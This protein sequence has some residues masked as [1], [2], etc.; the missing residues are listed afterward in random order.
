M[1]DTSRQMVV[2]R[3]ANEATR[4]DGLPLSPLSEAERR[5]LERLE[6][7]IH[8]A[9][10]Y[11]LQMAR[12]L[13]TIRQKRLYRKDH[14]TFEDYCQHRWSFTG[15]QGRRLCQ[16]VEVTQN[17]RDQ[18]PPIG[19]MVP[20]RESHARPLARLTPAQQRTAWRQYL[21]TVPASHSA[22]AIR[23]VCEQVAR[24]PVAE[25]LP[26]PTI[27]TAAEGAKPLSSPLTWYGGKAVLAQRIVDLLPPHH[28]YVEVFF[29]SGSVF[30]RKPPSPVEL[31]N[32]RNAEVVSFFQLLRDAAQAKEL[33]RLLR[34]TPY[35]RDEHD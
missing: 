29:G 24:A 11:M 17:L 8:T 25:G 20:L 27:G 10:R 1:S 34:L 21:R 13:W 7:I 12:A 33:Q 6:S 30:F 9:H 5:R 35:S 3:R 16:W 31:I 14:R 32:D 26:S 2:A 15:E 18:D 4:S 23:Q 19:G 28:S 22:K